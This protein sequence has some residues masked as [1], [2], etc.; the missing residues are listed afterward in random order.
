MPAVPPKIVVMVLGITTG[1]C[2]CACGA[3][4]RRAIVKSAETRAEERRQKERMEI[5]PQ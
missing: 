4:N 3:A 1:V 2:A 5:W